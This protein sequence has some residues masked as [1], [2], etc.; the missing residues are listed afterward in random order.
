M[1]TR[2]EQVTQALCD[3]RNVTEYC[4]ERAQA[5]FAAGDTEYGKA[6]LVAMCRTISNYEES[7]EINELTELWTRYRPLVAE[8]IP[9]SVVFNGV[10]PKTPAQCSIP[11]RDILGKGDDELLTELSDHV[12]EL[13]GMGAS[14]GVLNRWERTFYYADELCMELNSGG[15]EGYL[16][17]H[18][19]HFEKACCSVREVG[20]AEM[21][22]LLEAVRGKFPRGRIPKSEEAIQNAMDKLEDRGI[23]FE[24]EDD[25]YYGTAERELLDRL[26]AWVRANGERFR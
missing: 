8:L 25:R 23:D 11:I 19:T 16:Y 15:F 26:A 14:L 21:S 1:E 20:A 9:E 17:Y 2:I 12:G 10:S 7:L 24:A 18:G 3:V 6:Y 13:S 22:A 5:C 4:M